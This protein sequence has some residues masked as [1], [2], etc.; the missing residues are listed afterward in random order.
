LKEEVKKALETYNKVAKLY[1]KYTA[2]KLLQF[3]LNKFISLLPKKAKVLDVGCGSGRDVA[4]FIEEGLDATGIDTS[5]ELLKEAKAIV[6]RDKFKKMDM[7]SMSFKDG[8]F[9]GLWVMATLADIPKKD[10]SAAIKEFSRVLKT[11]GTV[12]IAVKEGQGEKVIKLEKYNNLPRFYSFYSQKELE[13]LLK[14]NNFKIISSLVSK[15]QGRSWVEV[16]AKK[17]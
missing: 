11:D 13:E 16:F 17:A 6:K 7:L 4:Y 14:Q 3:Q 1:V 9:D 15:D 8:S 10:S 5:E 12:Y 2:D